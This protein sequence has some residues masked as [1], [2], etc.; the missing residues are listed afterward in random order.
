M[1]IDFQQIRQQIKNLSGTAVERSDYLRRLQELAYELLVEYAA[2]LEGLRQ[3][4]ENVVRS[5]DP[6]LR[7]ALPASERLD[8]RFA[9]PPSPAEAV[10]LAAD[11]SQIFMDRHASVEYF[12]INIGVIQAHHGSSQAPRPRVF[13]DLSFGD[14]LGFNEQYFDDDK[15]SLIR[16]LRERRLLADLATEAT[17]D[18]GVLNPIPVITLTDGHLELWGAKTAEDD[19]FK[20]SLQEYLTSLDELHACAAITAGYVDKPGEDY[21][22]RLLE[23]ASQ[24]ENEAKNRPLRGV[25]DRRLFEKLL[26][27]GER[28]AVFGVQSRAATVYKRHAEALALHFFYLNIGRPDHPWLA[29]VDIPAWVAGDPVKLDA[30][31]AILVAQCKILGTHPYPYLLH[32]A[33][34]TAVV[35]QDERKQVEVMI[36][37]ELR[38]HGIAGEASHK[39]EMKQSG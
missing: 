16:D 4:V 17:A 10:I 37:Q 21:L 22:V 39:L 8:A 30:L 5:Y 26:K 25:R 18:L 15:I 3:K 34:E 32:R 11:G 38:K 29:R 24:P 9:T 35:G 2:D 36:N 31:H 19:Q 23:I 6:S 13:S 12:V 7:C 1:A 33:H 20:Q 27:P 28:S 14:Q